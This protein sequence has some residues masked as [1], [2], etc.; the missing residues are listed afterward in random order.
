MLGEGG[1]LLGEALA[2]W[3]RGNRHGSVAAGLAPASRRRDHRK[4]GTDQSMRPQTGV[5]TTASARRAMVRTLGG[6]PPRQ[7][8]EPRT[9]TRAGAA[10]RGLVRRPSPSSRELERRLVDDEPTSPAFRHAVSLAGGAQAGPVAHGQT[11]NQQERRVG[12]F[13][14]AGSR[15]TAVA[16]GG[17]RPARRRLA[18]T[19]FGPTCRPAATPAPASPGSRRSWGCATGRC[20]RC[21]HGRRYGWR[22]ATA[23]GAA[24]TAV[25]RGADRRPR[26]PA[27][28]RRRGGLPGRPG[29]AAGVAAGRGRRGVGRASADRA[30]APGP[31][32][33]PAGAA[34]ARRAGGS[35]GGASGTAG[36]VAGA[37]GGALAELGFGD[38]AGYLQARR[39]E[40]GWSVKRMRAE[41]GVGRGW[42]VGELPRLGLRP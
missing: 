22:P 20:R 37:S 2:A 23:T 14:R 10:P 38:L 16:I 29:D 7:G 19:T 24:A 34:H 5:L 1:Q 33:D 3:D 40:Q 41:L 32:R 6:P 39:V 18:S 9:R 12:W 25:H 17:W 35:R 42:L 27:G 4:H 28:L 30:P 8:I 36:V 31:L 15:S 21:W 26:G 11:H 13:S